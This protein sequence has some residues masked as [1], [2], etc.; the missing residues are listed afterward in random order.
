MNAQDGYTKTTMAD[1]LKELEAA[2]IALE[3]AEAE[4]GMAR[5]RAISAKKAYN[6]VTKKIDA[7]MAEI[8]KAAPS[9]TDWSRQERGK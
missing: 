1:L 9:D 8:R 6:A 7:A 3:N 2:K 5:G 4:E